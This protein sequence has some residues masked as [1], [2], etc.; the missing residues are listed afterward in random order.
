MPET[1]I[2]M[3]SQNPHPT[4]R[5]AVVIPVLTCFSSFDV[6]LLVFPCLCG[7]QNEKALE[8]F[9]NRQFHKVTTSD[10]PVIRRIADEDPDARLV[11]ATDS[12]LSTIMCAV[13]S[14]YSWDILVHKSGNK[15]YLDQ[16]D[17]A[18]DLLTV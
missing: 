7:S 15:L 8:R 12:I 14:V 4:P 18:F 6:F 3:R 5:R 9:E 10:D 2:S 13:R 17:A 16:R 1:G 11:F